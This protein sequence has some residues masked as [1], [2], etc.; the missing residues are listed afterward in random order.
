[1]V[2][3]YKKDTVL[4]L[5]CPIGEGAVDVL[6]EIAPFCLAA[7]RRPAHVP[8]YRCAFVVDKLKANYP[9]VAAQVTSAWRSVR[10]IPR[11]ALGW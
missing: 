7:E 3:F 4:A 8:N 1:M 9:V 2:G 5:Q 6:E 10:W 11:T